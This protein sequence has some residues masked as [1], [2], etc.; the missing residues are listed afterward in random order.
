MIDSHEKTVKLM[1]YDAVLAEAKI[2]AEKFEKAKMLALDA[3]IVAESTKNYPEYSP[4]WQAEYEKVPE[5]VAELRAYA[6]Q[7]GFLKGFDLE[8]EAVKIY[9]E[10]NNIEII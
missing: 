1:S 9:V 3:L 2:N 8:K 7:K 4:S 6:E 10:Q 5:S